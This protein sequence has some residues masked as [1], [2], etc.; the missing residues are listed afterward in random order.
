MRFWRFAVELNGDVKLGIALAGRR[1]SVGRRRTLCGELSGRKV[2]RNEVSI[3]GGGI[4][5]FGEVRAVS[6]DDG[7]LRGGCWMSDAREI[8]WCQEV[9]K[10]GIGLGH[11]TCI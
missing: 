11:V 9:R 8:S 5:G 4:V 10:W 7:V 3:V 2:G 1:G 6:V